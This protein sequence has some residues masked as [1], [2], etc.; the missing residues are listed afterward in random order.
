M[1]YWRGMTRR[2][3]CDSTCRKIR[4]QIRRQIRSRDISAFKRPRNGSYSAAH[5]NNVVTLPAMARRH[6]HVYFVYFLIFL[7]MFRCVK[8]CSY[9][10]SSVRALSNHQVRCEDYQKEEA[11]SA[12]IRK[13]IAARNKQKQVQRKQGSNKV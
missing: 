11:H 1:A 12:A 9:I 6:L 2:R 4:R 7:T 8:A 10:G 13:S 5:C 3:L